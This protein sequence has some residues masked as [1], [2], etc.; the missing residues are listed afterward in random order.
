MEIYENTNLVACPQCSYGCDPT[1]GNCPICQAEISG[2]ENLKKVS[3]SDPSDFVLD[4]S[5]L[6]KQLTPCPKCQ[7]ACDPGWD[8]CPI[9]QTALNQTADSKSEGT[10]GEN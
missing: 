4:E 3:D 2:L 9:C 1:W 10:S 8:K 6:K 7:Y 5:E